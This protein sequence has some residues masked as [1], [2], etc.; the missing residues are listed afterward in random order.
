MPF[1]A[2]I[3]QGIALSIS[4]AAYAVGLGAYAAT[5]SSAL[6]QFGGS[7]LLNAAATALQGRNQPTAQEIGRQLSQPTTKPVVRFIYGKVRATGTP[8]GTPV[9]GDVIWGCWLLNSR[10]SELPNFTLFLD[11]RE[12][13]LTGDAFDFDG[14]GATADEEPFDGYLNCWVSR[15]DK[16]TPPVMFTDDAPYDEGVRDDL[17]KTTDGWQGRT[18]IWIRL[19]AGP[20]GTRQ[21][22][23]P[24]TPPLVEVEG[25][26]SLI[27]D[28]R[29]PSHDPDDQDT[30]SS[31]QNHAL[32]VRDALRQNPI[33]AYGE[34]Q[35]HS[36]FEDGADICWE[37]VARKDGSIEKRYRCGGTLTFGDGEIEDQIIP[38]LVSGAAD[39]IRI[40]GQLGYAAGAYRAPELTLDEIMGD[41]FEFS[42]ML[43]GDSLVNQLRVSYLSA[44]R[45]FETAE[46]QPWS[47]PGALAADGGVPSVKSIDLKFCPSPTAAMRV[48]KILGG[49]LRRQETISGGEL[50]P[51][52]F[53]LVGGSTLTL[54][55]PVPYDELDGVY[56]V[57]AI[58]PG[59]NPLGEGRQLA[60]KMPAT[61]IKHD[62]AIY[63]YDPAVDEEEVLNEP[64]NDQRLGVQPPGAISVITGEA[65]NL[66]T[67]SQIIPQ[68]RFAFDP[69]PSGSVTGYEWQHQ[70]DFFTAFQVGG[71]I[72]SDVRDG[73]GDV[74]EYLLTGADYTETIR[75]RSIGPSGQSDWVEIVGVQATVSIDLDLPTDG[76][77]TGGAGAI[78]VSFRTPNDPDFRQIEIFGADTDDENAAALVGTAISAA[79]NTVVIVTDTGLGTSQTRYYF[80]RSRGDFASA[81]DFTASVSATTDP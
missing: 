4:A 11:K 54:A 55:L 72:G 61:L 16:T 41:S 9:Q 2:P 24:A 58:W 25:K 65:V 74:F 45:G 31:S 29:N 27:Y 17:W 63:D 39:L 68:I 51:E 80:A 59:A 38:M 5:I 43:P 49:R 23:W 37:D 66:N 30:W 1:L 75:V 13:S 32:C 40:G 10:R 70:P 76:Q 77:A 47:I 18:V 42:D 62:A 81:S 60:L 12:V 73:S 22:R 48:R 57:Q 3:I 8:V 28:P 53:D 34:D 79:A 71:I 33:R 64:F 20:N 36:S 56:E 46:L 7:L 15:G 69:S 19:V 50:P 21:E 78:E 44:E 67:G 35:L 26:W 14:D 6:I 52:A